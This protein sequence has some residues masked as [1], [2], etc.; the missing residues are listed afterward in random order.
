MENNSD[1]VVA[2][3]QML[4][5]LIARMHSAAFLCKQI[6]IAIVTG[7]LA[8]SAAI[9]EPAAC[10]IALLPLF[11]FWL[12]DA[13]YLSIERD[14]IRI[15]TNHAELTSRSEK[16][17]CFAFD[18]PKTWYHRPLSTA[19]SAVSFSVWPIYVTGIAT[20]VLL[21]LCGNYFGL[22]P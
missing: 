7:M 22:K 18:L 15:F 11:A 6:C 14:F 12:I 8:V 13:Y 3:F 2:H 1:Y 17:N 20:I 16:L 4:Q 19:I 10:L 9:K 21:V 5:S